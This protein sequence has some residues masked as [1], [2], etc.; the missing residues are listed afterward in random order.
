MTI[1]PSTPLL[2]ICATTS[3]HRVDTR[4]TYYYY[5]VLLIKLTSLLQVREMAVQSSFAVIFREQT[6]LPVANPVQR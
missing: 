2:C 3:L 4:S 5:Y 1:I 6:N